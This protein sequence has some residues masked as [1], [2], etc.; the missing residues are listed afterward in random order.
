MLSSWIGSV[1]EPMRATV[2]PAVTPSPLVIIGECM[3]VNTTNDGV[4]GIPN[5]ALINVARGIS[6]ASSAYA[7]SKNAPLYGAQIS[8]PSGMLNPTA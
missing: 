2:S 6:F 1:D 4:S 7:S 8:V 5:L 3:A